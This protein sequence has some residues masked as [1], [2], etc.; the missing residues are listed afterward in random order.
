MIK[1][2]KTE[3]SRRNGFSEEVRGGW[4]NTLKE[5]LNDEDL[6]HKPIKIWNADESGFTDETQCEWILNKSMARDS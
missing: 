2:K 5:I 1:E 4:F 3:Q 6:M